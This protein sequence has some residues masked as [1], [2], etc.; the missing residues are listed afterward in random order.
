MSVGSAALQF[1]L[2]QRF[3]SRTRRRPAARRRRGPLLVVA[4]S[5]LYLHGSRWAQLPACVWKLDRTFLPPSV[6]P[7]LSETHS[8]LLRQRMNSWALHWSPD[9]K[10]PVRTENSCFCPD[11]TDA[12]LFILLTLSSTLWLTDFSC[13]SM[14]K[15]SFTIS[16]CCK[17]EPQTMSGGKKCLKHIY[18]LS[19]HIIF[20]LKFHLADCA[21]TLYFSWK[22]FC[23]DF[24]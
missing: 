11:A 5:W 3:H 4:T 24:S 21:T 16:V 13:V 23:C 6:N 9:A 2:F 18:H 7:V 22:D 8:H 12:T 19:K 15:P 10:F 14:N 17:H 1:R 20:Y